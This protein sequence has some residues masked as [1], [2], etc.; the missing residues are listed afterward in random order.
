MAMK[1]ASV[2]SRMRVDIKQQAAQLI[3]IQIE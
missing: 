3:L 2:N 1:T